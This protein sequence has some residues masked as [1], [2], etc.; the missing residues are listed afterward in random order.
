MD[1]GGAE[2]HRLHRPSAVCLALLGPITACQKFSSDSSDVRG[3]HLDADRSEEHLELLGIDGAAAIEVELA[4]H[5]VQVIAHFR[6]FSSSTMTPLPVLY[7]LCSTS[8][9]PRLL[10]INKDGRTEV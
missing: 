5:H 1:V 7:R 4:K 8:H 9:G 6:S 10:F 3:S 2:A